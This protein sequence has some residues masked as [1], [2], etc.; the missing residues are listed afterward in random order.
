VGFHEDLSVDP[1][2]LEEKAMEECEISPT[3][4]KRGMFQIML[5]NL[6]RP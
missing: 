5:W 2:L 6:P 1:K 3:K 4:K